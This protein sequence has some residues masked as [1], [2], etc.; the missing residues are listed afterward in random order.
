MDG[1]KIETLSESPQ[2]TPGTFFPFVELS[3]TF[4]GSE[5]ARKILA[6]L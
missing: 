3:Q 1:R 2:N 4:S 5:E 6:E